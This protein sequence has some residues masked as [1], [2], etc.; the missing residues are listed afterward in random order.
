MDVEL[1]LAVV[2][3]VVAY[4]RRQTKGG[5]CCPHQVDEYVQS[6][7]ATRTGVATALLM[8]GH[9]FTPREMAVARD[10]VCSWQMEG[11]IMLE[12]HSKWW[13]AALS[14]M[15]ELKTEEREMVVKKIMEG[16]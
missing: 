12:A 8:R 13:V 5:W 1:A 2:R 10:T 7:L 9:I 3:K 4:A 11:R 15:R 6:E 14:A 16:A